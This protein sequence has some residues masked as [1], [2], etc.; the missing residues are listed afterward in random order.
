MCDALEWC[1]YAKARKRHGQNTAFIEL[2]DQPFKVLWST[3]KAMNHHEQG[4]RSG[5]V[6]RFGVTIAAFECGDV[7]LH[8]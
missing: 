1:A 5:N 2:I 8:K 7:V 6:Q 3:R 4:A